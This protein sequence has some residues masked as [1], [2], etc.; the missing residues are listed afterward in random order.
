MNERATTEESA[1]P[2]PFK[3][4][5][6]LLEHYLRPQAG[7]ATIMAALLL[8]S[9]GLQLLIPQI[10]RRFIDTAGAGVGAQQLVHLALGFLVVALLNQLFGAAATYLGADVG[11]TAT[12]LLRLDLARHCVGLDMS[13]HNARTS[14]EMI[15][16]IDGDVTALSNFF[17]QFSV[18]VFGAAL[19]LAGTLALLWREDPRIG[20]G[21][22]L[23]ALLE[24]VVLSRTRNVAVPA[25]RLERET[26]AGLFGFI[27]ER[28]SGIEDLRA[29]GGGAHAMH[30][31]A[32]KMR[33]YFFGT[34]RAWM[35]RSVIWL[36]S[37]G[38]FVLGMILTLGASITL[39]R[40][41]T[42]TLGT[43]YL[44]FQYMLML[45]AP[46][47]QITQQ[48]Q[49]LQRAAAGIGRIQD[50]FAASSSLT[51]GAGAPLP[52]GP[53]SVEF[54]EVGF[55]YDHRPVLEDVDL[56]LE[57]GRVLGLLGRTGSGKTTLTRLLFRFYEPTKGSV[58]LGGTDLREV[59]LPVLRSRI[60]LVTQE[61]QL[62]RAS[63]RDNLT[64]FDPDTPDQ[65]LLNVL[66]ELG[67][68]TWYE[69]LP[70]GLNTLVSAGGGNLSAGEAQL[71]A[72]ARV[73]LKDPGLVILDEPSSRLDPA[74]ELRL[75]RALNR[76]LR[77]RTAIIVAHRLET[78]ERADDVLVMGGGRVLEHGARERLAADPTSH[79]ASLLCSGEDLDIGD[80]LREKET[81]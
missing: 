39:V 44:V 13:F 2:T 32:A 63:V 33:E 25:T 71:L 19:L 46:I 43:A 61:V 4:F 41:G 20:L 11:W 30:R 3:Q 47:E 1:R 70:D 55:A 12:N 78:V 24:L 74:T 42:I 14:G 66:D 64:F 79:Y 59:D 65:R 22:T 37:Y 67:L 15:E 58:R 35:M 81:A 51:S 21:L 10:L 28:L 80:E 36:S 73:F 54:V 16:R 17:S 6:I 18:R 72:L 34:R 57:P 75:E 52:A 50:L 53:L 76:L 48:M 23:F 7:K 27:E 5:G 68:G 62:F 38:L 40:S 26:S 56:R 8:T 60:G 69:G 77:G 45:Q 49:E 31:F 9:I 29:N